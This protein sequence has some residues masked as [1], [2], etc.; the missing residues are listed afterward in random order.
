MIM[1]DVCGFHSNYDIHSSITGLLS[2]MK[3]I[4]LLCACISYLNIAKAMERPGEAGPSKNFIL[5]GEQQTLPSHHISPQVGAAM[6]GNTEYVIPRGSRVELRFPSGPALVG[7]IRFGNAPGFLRNPDEPVTPYGELYVHMPDP[8]TKSFY[9]TF[10]GGQS[11]AQHDANLI[12]FEAV[13]ITGEHRGFK[14]EL[15]SHSTGDA[16]IPTVYVRLPASKKSY[17]GV[18]NRFG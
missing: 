15:N 9:A 6:G 7:E 2:K 18:L 13:I 14:S 4:T 11:L 10:Q 1:N 5:P 12:K 8:H 17:V 3:I 16:K